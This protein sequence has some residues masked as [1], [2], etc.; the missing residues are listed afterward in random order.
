MPEIKLQ[1]AIILKGPGEASVV[2]DLSI[3]SP[4]IGEVLIKVQAVSLNPSDWMARDH[5]GR[6]GAGM[7]FDFAGTV[8]EVGEGVQKVRSVG[9]RV[10]GFVHGCHGANYSIGAFREYLTADAALLIHIPSNLEFTEA[11]TL[12]MGV[13]TAAQ[14]LYQNLPL[15]IPCKT[16]VRTNQAILIYSGSTATGSLAIQLAKL[17]GFKVITTCSEKNIPW[18]HSLGADAVVDYNQID[19]IRQVRRHIEDRGLFIILDCV[20]KD[21]TAAFCYQCFAP[22]LSAGNENAPWT[23]YYASLMP[24]KNLPPPP[25]MIPKSA[26]I[27]AEWNMVFT[28][29]GRRFTIVNEGLGLNRT[30]EPSAVDREF[31]TFF[32][33][34]VEQIIPLGKIK[35]MPVEVREGGLEGVLEGIQLVKDGGA[36]GKKLVYAL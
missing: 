33:R 34:C 15:P 20:S 12:G 30:W 24:V 18:L 13:S 32:Y 26:I 17:S 27:H 9:D 14:H 1:S 23:F 25:I 35:L 19:A 16:S 36:L 3:P 22:P 28:C 29:F 4:G 6:P 21:A 5:L 11:A 10:A 2:K 8:L 7:G 31:M